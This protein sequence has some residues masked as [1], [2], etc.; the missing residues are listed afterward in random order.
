MFNF[1]RLSGQGATRGLQAAARRKVDLIATLGEK[2]LGSRSPVDWTRL[3]QHCHIRQMIAQ[4]VPGFENLL[5][6]DEKREEFQIPGRTFH[7]PRFSTPNGQSAVQ[8]SH[9]PAAARR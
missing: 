2:V 5:T 7:T 8:D 3:K 9:D 1:V 4:I 6:I